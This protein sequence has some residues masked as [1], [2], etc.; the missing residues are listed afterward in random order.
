MKIVTKRCTLLEN[1]FKEDKY[2]AIKVFENLLKKYVVL[3]KEIITTDLDSLSGTEFYS[4]LSMFYN[5]Q[6]EPE[7]YLAALSK[8]SS[9]P[10]DRFAVLDTYMVI[11][12]KDKSD[13]GSAVIWNESKEAVKLS[14]IANKKAKIDSKKKYYTSEIDDM[15]ENKNIV[16]IGILRE[17]LDKETKFTE[18]YKRYP[19]LD[20]NHYLRNNLELF[21]NVLR[22]NLP[23]QKIYNDLKKFIEELNYQLNTVTVYNQVLPQD[24]ND[25]IKNWWLNSKLKNELK[26][27]EK[28]IKKR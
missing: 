11:S 16:I 15:V 3:L 9:I 22:D 8:E 6:I 7:D 28:N 4:L 10:Y 26:Q 1:T 18:N 14:V 25:Q 20:M 19:V 5:I 21:G 2:S 17:Q 24:I 13:F 27:T 23:K 12:S